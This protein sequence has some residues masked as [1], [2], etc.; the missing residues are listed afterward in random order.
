MLHETRRILKV[1]DRDLFTIPSIDLIN[2]LGK[3]PLGKNGKKYWFPIWNISKKY[4][5]NELRIIL[6]MLSGNELSTP[7]IRRYFKMSNSEVWKIM[8][9]LEESQLIL[10]TEK[11]GRAQLWTIA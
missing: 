7:E 5:T 3:I 1:N 11:L 6:N 4:S 9:E 10:R 2:H 8:S